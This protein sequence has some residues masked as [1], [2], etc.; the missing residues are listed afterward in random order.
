MTW[1]NRL[2]QTRRDRL[3]AYYL[4]AVLSAVVVYAI[5]YDVALEVFEGQSQPW[6]RSLGV[7]VESMTTTGYGEDAPWTSVQVYLLVIAMQATGVIFLFT[8]L[9]VIALPL[10]REALANRAPSA[11]PNAEDHV[12]ICAGVAHAEALIDDLESENV[13]YVIVEPDRERATDLFDDGHQVVHGSPESAEDLEAVHVSNARWVVVEAGD[14]VNASIV[15]TVKSVAPD[16]PVASVTERVEREEYH[17]LAGAD[18]VF[19]PRELV[20]E[21]LAEKAS[22]TVT[23]DLDEAVAIGEGF[24]LAE[25]AVHSGSELVGKRLQDTDIRERTGANVIGAWI[26]G[27]F[28]VPPFEKPIDAHTVLLVAG[29]E[30]QCEALNDLTLSAHRRHGRGSATVAGH[31]ETGQAVVDVLAERGIDHSVI[32]IEDHAAVD[33][34]GDA[35]DPESLRAAGIDDARSVV[36]ALGNDADTVFATL[37]A[38]ELAPDVEIIARA[39]DRESVRKIYRAGA[40]Y[41]LALSRVTGRL[42]AASVLEQ[43]LLSFETHVKVVRT[44]AAHLAGRTLA[45]ADVRQRTGCTVIGVERDGETITGPEPDFELAAGDEV[46]VAGSDE[47]IAAFRDLT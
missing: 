22:T 20:G 28:C 42:L 31:G 11:I 45:G 34:V 10:I 35:T 41:V 44:P 39:N 13:E 14:E 24:E 3:I 17:R 32:D 36:L 18:E 21:R 4:A 26:D 6:Y 43:D 37:V 38:R 46:I 25:L 9:P 15:L 8:A 40:D 47:G 27:E 12:V 19:S 30:G 23:A 2:L 5:A 29:D 16:V 7:V 1:Y 33:V